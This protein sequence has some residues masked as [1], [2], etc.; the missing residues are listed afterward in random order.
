MLN[1]KLSRG[2]VAVLDRH[3]GGLE[4]RGNRRFDTV[5]DCVGGG[6]VERVAR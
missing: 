2:A 3:Q 1:T 6:G 5:I 4:V